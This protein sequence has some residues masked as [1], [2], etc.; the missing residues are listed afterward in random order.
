MFVREVPGFSFRS[1]GRGLSRRGGWA[2]TPIPYRRC[3][4]WATWGDRVPRFLLEFPS[5]AGC[6]LPWPS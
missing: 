2:P 5:G 6:F 3:G 1:R 4:D